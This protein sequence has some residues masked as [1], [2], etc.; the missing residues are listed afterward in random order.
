MTL[1]E[2]KTNPVITAMPAETLTMSEMEAVTGGNTT[3]FGIGMPTPINPTQYPKVPS[4][5]EY[6]PP[7]YIL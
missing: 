5:F 1:T 3:P 7:L 2:R 6:A 4:P